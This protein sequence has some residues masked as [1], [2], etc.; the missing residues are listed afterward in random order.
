MTAT[1]FRTPAM[2]ALAAVGVSRADTVY[3]VSFTTGELVRYDSADP[4]GT[5]VAPAVPALGLP[6]EPVIWIADA[7]GTVQRRIDVVWDLEE[8]SAVLADALS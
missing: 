4:A 2:L 1:R 8:L 3:V 7:T 6:Y 5:K